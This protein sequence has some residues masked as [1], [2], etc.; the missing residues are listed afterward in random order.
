MSQH[1]IQ[2]DAGLA[3]SL[4]QVP[5]LLGQVTQTFCPDCFVVSFKLETEPRILLQKAWGA[6]QKYGVH[7]VVANLLHTRYQECRLVSQRYLTG[8][9][10]VGMGIKSS[11]LEEAA[12]V[13]VVEKQAG[14]VWLEKRLVAAVAAVHREP[15]GYAP[16]PKIPWSRPWLRCT[17]ST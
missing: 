14:E 6:V 16:G 1:K 4:K 13:L 17:G 11:D 9:E 3:L 2:S 12:R 7:L 10:G 15:P 8:A 5:K